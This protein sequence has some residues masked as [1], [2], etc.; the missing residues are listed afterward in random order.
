MSVLGDSE[1]FRRQIKEIRD[2]DVEVR[3]RSDPADRFPGENLFPQQGYMWKIYFDG[4]NM[5]DPNHASG[6]GEDIHF[7]ALSASIPSLTQEPVKRKYAGVEYAYPGKDNSPKILR[8]TFWDNHRL[9]AF[10]FFQ[11][12]FYMSN[13]PYARRKTSPENYYRDVN[14]ELQQADGKTVSEIFT[15]RGCFPTEISEA[16]LSYETSEAF[17]FDVQFNFFKRTTGKKIR[18]I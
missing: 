1:V 5:N 2:P 14:I 17:T 12:W 8:V 18:T 16:P 6:N 13:D 10:H 3:K 7:Q 15:F 4:A 11:R 9:D